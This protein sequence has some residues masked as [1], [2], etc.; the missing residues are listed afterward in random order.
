M[1]NGFNACHHFVEALPVAH[2]GIGRDH[3]AVAV[4][5]LAPLCA[6]HLCLP[7]SGLGQECCRRCRGCHHSILYSIGLLCPC[8]HNVSEC[9]AP[10]EVDILVGVEALYHARVAFGLL[11]ELVDALQHLLRQVDRVVVACVVK[12]DVDKAAAGLV[13]ALDATLEGVVVFHLVNGGFQAGDGFVDLSLLCQCGGNGGAC[14]RRQILQAC[15]VGQSRCLSVAAYHL[16]LVTVV[17]GNTAQ[18]R[19]SVGKGGGVYLLAFALGLINQ[20]PTQLTG[21]LKVVHAAVVGDGLQVEGPLFRHVAH[22]AR[23]VDEQ[24]GP[25]R[26]IAEYAHGFRLGVEGVGTGGEGGGAAVVVCAGRD[27]QQ[28]CEQQVVA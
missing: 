2:V 16:G 25:L 23:R 15:H 22:D 8:H 27:R 5:G 12:V 18:E 20:L 3:Q 14:H 24:Q 6:S 13:V 21:L 4:D 10:H 28:D 17:S 26:L 11:F 7:A 9:L 19:P 1:F